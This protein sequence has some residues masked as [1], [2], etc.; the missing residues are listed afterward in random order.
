MKGS[1]PFAE[2]PT[3]RVVRDE[4]RPRTDAC[5]PEIGLSQPQPGTAKVQAAHDAH[6]AHD[7]LSEEALDALCMKEIE[8]A[9]DW[10][11]RFR[12]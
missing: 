5:R 7:A 10:R 4:I 12:S 8:A 1:F 3:H 9:T 11:R 2:P 6:A